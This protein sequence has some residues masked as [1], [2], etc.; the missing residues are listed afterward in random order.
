MYTL[1]HDEGAFSQA[2][3]DVFSAVLQRRPMI[4]QCLTSA[5]L[6]GASDVVAQQLVEKRGLKNHDVRPMILR[7]CSRR[8]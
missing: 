5:V 1:P 6:F 4:S 2:N 8:S 7:C 3:A